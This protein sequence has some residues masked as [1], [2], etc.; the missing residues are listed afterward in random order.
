MQLGPYDVLVVGAG[1]AG[2]EAAM[3]S[4]KMGADTLLL[5]I[6]LD[7]VGKMSCN[8]SIGGLAKGQ[9]AREIDALGGVMGEA[10]DAVGLHFH[11][12]NTSK[13]PAVQ[14]PRAQADKN[15]YHMYMKRR[16]EE[17]ENLH[18]RQDKV[19]QLLLD[20]NEERIIGVK[21]NYG[22]SYKADTV[23]LT[24]GTF[25]RGL[26]HMG[27]SKTEAGR[28][29]E[30]P[31][32]SISA[33][34]REL[35]FEMD[36]AKTGTPPRLNGRT[37]N[38]D[39]MEVQQPDEDPQPFSY[40]TNELEQDQ[41]P[42]YKTR[43]NPEVHELI[44]DNLDRAPMYTGQIDAVGVRYCPSIEDKVAK[45]E[46]RDSHTVFIEPE[47][48]DTIEIY[49]N[50][51]STSLPMDVQEQIVD[52]IE[53][54][55]DAEITR[56]GY[57]IE[58]DFVQPTQLRPNLE[59]EKI[60]GLYF[61]GQING[62]TGY[63]EAGCQG[64]LAGINA[65]CRVLDK[66]ELVLKRYEAYTGVL[67]DDLVTQGVTEPYRMF[68]SRAE[69]RLLLRHDNADR[70]L[71]KHA[72][73]LGL[74]SEER[75]EHVEKKQN[76][77]DRVR[78]YMEDEYYE[79]KT[80][81]TY[82]RQPERDFSDIRE[83]DPDVEEFDLTDEEVRQVEIETKYEGYIKRELKKVEKMKEKEEKPI[84]DEID[85]DEVP[86]IRAESREKLSEVQP[87]TLG[88]AR[89]ISGVSPADVRMLMIYMQADE[90]RA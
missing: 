41:M 25:M 39:V 18:L 69:Y 16:C 56:Y 30:P 74:I 36:R 84:P 67:I 58:Y 87:E 14:S 8:P 22:I 43:T 2:I 89:R 32:E 77:I 31:A 82:L 63:E 64:L 13:G 26:V 79:G 7:T 54:L 62:T 42:C 40:T 23:V 57:A 88:Q 81:Q 19:K 68:T 37:V 28:A 48:R 27:E 33:S 55:E 60:R 4:A 38:Y 34:L 71:Y 73:R 90:R 44:R 21:G 59:T 9:I 75:A 70:R 85:F 20:D 49:P 53:G 5:T 24:T 52:K 1:H 17:Q 3:A 35:G 61:A 46:D 51:I 10:I 72:R 86:H 45:F 83:M 65:A 12:L 15:A 80:L 50:G 66:E 47:G 76:Q 11:M 6:N 78:D 29:W